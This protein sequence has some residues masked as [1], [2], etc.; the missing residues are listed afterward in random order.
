[1]FGTSRELNVGPVAIVSLIAFEALEAAGFAS[2]DLSQCEASPPL[3]DPRCLQCVADQAAWS[4]AAI[5]MAFL[6]GL[7]QVVCGLLHLGVLASF[8]A[9]PVIT[10][11]NFASVSRFR[12]CARWLDGGGIILNFVVRGAEGDFDCWKSAEIGV[13]R[14]SQQPIDGV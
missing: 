4:Q 12:G 11:F 3:D 13:W 9:Q 1:M 5:V 8:L 14:Q 10:G 7:M 2:C 6:S